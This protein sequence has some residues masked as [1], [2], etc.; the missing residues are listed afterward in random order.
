MMQTPAQLQGCRMNKGIMHMHQV[1]A[2]IRL[3]R[4]TTTSSDAGESS[5]KTSSNRQR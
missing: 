2:I 1:R 5:C 4:E 3:V